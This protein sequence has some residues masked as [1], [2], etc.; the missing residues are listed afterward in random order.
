MSVPPAVSPFVPGRGGLPPYLAGRDNEQHAL[1]GLLAYLEHGR[2]APRDVIV[3][4]PRGRR[5]ELEQRGLAG[6]SVSV[7]AAFR[8]SA[9]LTGRALKSATAAALPGGSSADTLQIQEKLASVGYVW[10][11]PGAGN[12]R[13]PGIPSLMSHIETTERHGGAAP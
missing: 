5:Y 4:G 9:T 13:E 7:A 2:G 1:K 6:V 10:R 8:E 3:V 11:S 12:L